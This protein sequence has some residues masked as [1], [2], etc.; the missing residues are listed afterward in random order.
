MNTQ[1]SQNK[2]DH[3]LT[4]ANRLSKMS[5]WWLIDLYKAGMTR[6]ITE[7][8]VYKSID[9]H[10]CDRIAGKFTKIWDEELKQKNPSTIRMFCKAYGFPVITYGLLFSI[11]ETFLRCAQPL[12]LG[13]LITNFSDKNASKQSSYIY[14]SG[15][16]LCSLISVISFHPFIYYIFEIGMKFRVGC[17]RLVYDKVSWYFLDQ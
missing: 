5:F 6:T 3:P 14:A 8:D 2:P 1:D 13:E 11:L 9:H 12:L 15:I 17:S 4:K 7:Q 10:E 16:V